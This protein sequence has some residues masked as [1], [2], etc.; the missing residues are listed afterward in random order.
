MILALLACA[1]PSV[2]GPP[3][4]VLVS[5]DGLRMDRTSLS[6]E[7]DTT[8][9]LARHAA[10]GL[11]FSNAFSASNESALS[12][13]VL[14][15][16]RHVPE[17]AAPDY[18]TF[19][20][21]EAATT[22]PEALQ[23]VGYETA[24]VL[25]GGHVRATFG[26]GQGWD[27]FVEITD[28]GSFQES[29]PEALRWLDERDGDAPFFLMV[30][31]YDLHRPYAKEGPFWHAYG[32]DYEGP[33]CALVSE[34][35]ETE[36]IFNGMLYPEHERP[37]M[38]HST[39]AEMSDPA[40]YAA[41][42]ELRGGGE[43]L[44]R[45]DLAHMRDHYDSGALAADFYVGAL[46]DSLPENTVVLITSDHGEDLQDHGVSNH[47]AVLYDSTTHVPFVVLG[48]GVGERQDLAHAADVVPT[49]L[50]LAG[51]VSPAGARGLDLLSSERGSGVFQQ[52]V[53][54]QSS[55]RTATHR[56]VF[57]G[58]ALDAPEYVDVASEGDFETW[59][60]LYDLDA[61][62]GEKTNVLAENPD[63]ANAM[64]SELVEVLA[65]LAW[66][67]ARKTPSPE[68]LEA[69]RSRGYW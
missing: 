5:I 13:G 59:F 1:E 21:P 31:G 28:F 67:D 34:R 50:A 38:R 65:S 18:R 43:P 63:V 47:R 16:G 26:F 55:I 48:A 3:N 44:S 41:G 62:P 9:N 33:M 10:N 27:H 57:E 45:Q 7:R 19:L 52:G 14:L 39:G 37:T 4:L 64:R 61:D 32:S 49:L 53:T 40:Q 68:V 42:L 8:P 46:L 11:V 56:L 35:N 2:D 30:H 17:I 36:R 54:G 20:V 6:G 24:G 66:S 29:V 60:R 23:Q 69:M 51:T 12:H 22:L 25:A 58:L 15:T